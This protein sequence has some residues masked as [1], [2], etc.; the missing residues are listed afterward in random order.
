[1]PTNCHRQCFTTR[2]SSSFVLRL[3]EESCF[4]HAI[5]NGIRVKT[6]P[7]LPLPLCFLLHAALSASFM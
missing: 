1:M 6:V 4:N 3:G 7:F 2:P 5:G